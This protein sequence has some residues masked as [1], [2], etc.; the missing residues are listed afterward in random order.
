MKLGKHYK[1][2]QARLNQLSDDEL[3]VAIK[4][5]KEHINWR[6]K[7]HTLYGV[8]TENNLGENPH[9]YYISTSLEKLF[10]GQWEWKEK[11][12]L[13]EQLIRISDSQ[14]SKEI[15]K[16]K[17]KKSHSFKLIYEDIEQSFY[18]LADNSENVSEKESAY[19]RKI[20]IIEEAIKEDD[21][22]NILL[23]AVKA[24][25]KASEIAELLGKTPK[26]LGK[27][28]ERLIR[29]VKNYQSKKTEE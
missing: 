4:K 6:L 7:Q 21:E 16:S 28:K 27:I 22:L 17:T 2:N 3:R 29:K 1:S 20:N 19:Q 14:I 9:N 18:D 24:G 12:S 25:Y 10:L 26:Q 8:H 5:C 11:H 23:D 15:E 13:T